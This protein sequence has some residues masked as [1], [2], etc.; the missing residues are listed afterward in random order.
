MDE[1]T[2]IAT[3]LLG[4]IRG[5]LLETDESFGLDSDLFAA[6]LDSISIGKAGACAVK[7]RSPPSRCCVG[8]RPPIASP[9]QLADGI[10]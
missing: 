10:A 3:R 6:G 9:R 7:S 1:T 8:W 4:R 5:E 2:R